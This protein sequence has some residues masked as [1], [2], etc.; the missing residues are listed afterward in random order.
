MSPLTDWSEGDPVLFY[1]G[2]NWRFSNFAAVRFEWNG[3]I[4][5]TAEHAYQARKFRHPKQ[6]SLYQLDAQ[7]VFNVIRSANDPGIAKE[8][9]HSPKHTHL[10]SPTWEQ[11][12]LEI[13]CEI[14]LEQIAQNPKL[15]QNLLDTGSAILV[16]NSSTDSF[17][18]RGPNW[19]GKN[20]LGVIIMLIRDELL[21]ITNGEW[22]KVFRE[23]VERCK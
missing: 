22:H 11:D 9:A 23:E 20:M 13:M 2:K 5:S 14:K 15:Q 17:W 10:I 8:I 1:S 18:G 7:R 21:D 16:E 6:A 4:W 19:R 12:K 3:R